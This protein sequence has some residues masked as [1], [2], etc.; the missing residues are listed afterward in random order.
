MEEVM[1]HE[2]HYL[3]VIYIHIH[4]FLALCECEQYDDW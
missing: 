1:K 4:H 3:N 2:P